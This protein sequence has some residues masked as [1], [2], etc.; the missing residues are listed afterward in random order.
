MTEIYRSVTGSRLFGCYNANSDWDYKS[1][2]IPTGRQIVLGGG[3]NIWDSKS[4][5]LDTQSFPLKKYLNLLAKMELNSVEL[6]FSTAS[7]LKRFDLNPIW[8]E[9]W[10]NRDKFLSQNKKPFVGFAKGQAMRYAV[11]GD[12]FNTLKS[13]V[14]YLSVLQPKAKLKDAVP[15]IYLNLKKLEGVEFV[16]QPDGEYLSVFSRMVPMGGTALEAKKVYEK[17]LQEAG[18]RT[19]I[20]SGEGGVDWKGL[21]HAH[22][23]VDEG[24]EL[25]KTGKIVFPLKNCDLYTSIRNQ[26][27]PLE[28][29]LDTFLEKIDKLEELTET[30]HLREKPDAKWLE[31]FLYRVYYKEVTKDRMKY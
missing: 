20:A 8:K 4:D 17:P 27:L 1:V 13:V 11:R 18:E 24:L 23:V 28:E 15:N 25:W 21:Y 9:L 29:V 22:R 3:N 16:R 6:L 10:D 30:K 2:H 19:K 26:E 31:D 5:D 7:K 12:R 14:D